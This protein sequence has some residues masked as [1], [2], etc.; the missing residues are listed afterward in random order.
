M[1]P[2]RLRPSP[3]A[4]GDLSCF[5]GRYAW[6]DRQVDVTATAGGLLISSED[7]R[8]EALPLSERTFLVD[9]DSPAVTFGAFDA[10]GLPGS[11][12]RCCGGFRGWADAQQ[13]HAGRSRPV[14]IEVNGTRLWFD[15]EGPAL[16]PDGDRMRLRPT[17]VLVHGGPG[18]YDHSY[19]KPDF[20]RLAEC[21]QAVY[22]DLRGHGRSGLGD[23]AEWSFE[24]CADDIRAFCDALG[25]VVPVVLGHSMGGP[26]VLLYGARH[27]GH[28]AGLIIASGFAR[29]DPPRMVE[30]LPGDRRYLKSRRSPGAATPVRRCPRRSGPGSLPLSDRGSRTRTARRTHPVTLS[31]TRTGWSS[32]GSLTSSIS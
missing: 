19:F 27:P 1:P 8:A 28:A 31:S 32:C 30:A 3:D 15:V 2:L 21:A 4:A 13:A 26:I 14:H 10:S 22:L 20:A 7:G 9:P 5:T 23:A 11:C 6:P 17:V 29:W 24:S 25:V 12:T 16:V 18:G